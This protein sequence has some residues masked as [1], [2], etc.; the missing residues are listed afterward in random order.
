MGI[1]LPDVHVSEAQNGWPHSHLLTTFTEQPYAMVMIWSWAAAAHDG[2]LIMK[3]A[4][5]IGCMHV[6]IRLKNITNSPASQ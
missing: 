1:L 6:S 3:K 4:S 2:L 5:A